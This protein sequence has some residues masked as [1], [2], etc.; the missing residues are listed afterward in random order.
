MK[1]RSTIY[2]AIAVVVLGATSVP[3]GDTAVRFSR[4]I[5][6]I[7]SENCFACHG[8]D[9]G[10]RKASLR[11]DTED[12]AKGG[13]ESPI[14]RDRAS[15]ALFQRLTAQDDDLMPPAETGKV[16]TA[17][18]IETIGQ[19]LDQ[20]APWEGHWAY[21][22]PVK[23]TPRPVRLASWPRGPV[24]QYV[25]ARLESVGYEP[26][27][28]ADTRTLIRRLYLDLTGLPPSPEAVEQFLLDNRPDAYERLVDDLLA[29]PH[30]GE[31][32]GRW[33]LDLTMY[34]DSD[35]YLS[36]FIRPNAWRYRQWVVDAFN[37]DMPF[38]QFTTEQL[39]GDLLPD[40]T[41][42]QRI[43]TGFLRNTLSNREG[44][45]DLEE[46]RTYQTLDR[47]RNAGTV[48]LGLT[49][50]CAQCHDHKYDAFSQQDYYQLYAF[51][52]NADEVNIDAPRNDEAAAY[53]AVWPEYA[54][55]RD[56]LLAP[57][58]EQLEQ[59]QA[60]WE[61]K[62]LWAAANPGGPDARWDRAWE[63]LG[64]VWGQ[65][66]AGAEGQ[67]EGTVIAQTPVAKRVRSEKFRLQDYFLRNGELVN[68]EKFKD[69]KVGEL[70]KQ[71]DELAKT[72]P[73][74][75]RAPA[76]RQ[77]RFPRPNHLFI[78]GDFRAPG[79][80]VAPATPAALA[81]FKPDGAPN[82]LDLARW[83][84]A[85]ENP[86]TARVVVNRI[87]QQLFGRGIV[88]SSADF[89][90]RGALPSHPDLLDY[91]A[92]DFQ[93]QGWRIKALIKEIVLSA[94]YRQSADARPEL[95]GTD[96]GNAL[97]A[98]QNRLR[99]TAE[100]VRDS[101]LFVSG[102][103]NTA[104]GGPSVKPPQPASVTKEGFDNKWVAEEG[105]DRY[106][107]ALYTFIQ[108]TSPF[109]QLVNFNFADVNRPCTRRERSNTP[110][111]ALNLLNDANFFEAAQALAA[112]ATSS[113]Q[114]SRQENVA[115]ASRLC[116]MNAVDTANRI[117]GLYRT[118]LARPA[119]AAEVSRMAELV[120][121]QLDRFKSEPDAV[122]SIL[123]HSGLPAS[124]ES[125]AWVIAASV[126]LNLDEFINRE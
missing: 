34:A 51:F 20:G 87:W 67:L 14:G 63:V 28:E 94:T 118:A 80:P 52:N 19:W 86:L 62:C 59:L 48:W 89:G 103:L 105:P 81:P 95:Q 25:L 68:P 102:L 73:P 69:L 84:T 6:P 31:H 126:V 61:E 70:V 22:P 40:A 113:Q 35:G 60:Q 115:Q 41:V 57:V 98:R 82:R 106:R 5:L 123:G 4:D 36:D 110:L 42:D 122:P 75:S 66:E 50:E 124:P 3:A 54:A 109:G 119:T 65:G 27:P 111:Q 125:A 49:V 11:L 37:A 117:N 30:F 108:R 8:A 56:A 21:T 16:L 114:S 88:A 77:A 74:M 26:S 99:L 46:Y 47:T 93:E 116:I 58:A 17:I 15:S 120:A 44:G 45:A 9:K 96:P 43:A 39:A 1:V 100:Q 64:L 112:R 85:P 2:I 32:W 76:M 79:D 90:V 53:A 24:D 97:L 7:L 104:L 12:G 18:Q 92:L 38:D 101:A 91:L 23:V 107:R 72:L 121:D 71:L 33:W 55:K 78:R 13:A 83:L 10:A 29:S